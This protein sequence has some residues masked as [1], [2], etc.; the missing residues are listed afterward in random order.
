MDEQ[1][2]NPLVEA[3]VQEEIP[4]SAESPQVHADRVRQ[5][6]SDS[7]QQFETRYSNG[8]ETIVERLGEA[9]TVRPS[10][11]KTFEDP[12]AFQNAV[13]AGKAVYQLLEFAPEN[14]KKFFE[15]GLE[16]VKEGNYPKAQEVFYFLVMM[17]SDTPAFWLGL[18]FANAKLKNFEEARGAFRQV[19]DLDPKNG[20]AY[21]GCMSALLQQNAKEEALKVCEE[22]LTYADA[23]PKEPWAE[24]LHSLLE[25]A[26][27]Y[28]KNRGA[29]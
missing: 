17:A 20:D 4:S 25:E 15:V 23:H 2:L 8:Y 3:L 1:S 29:V 18:G 28:M 10:A 19:I 11:L 9:P 12:V 26:R 5:E 21:L 24:P 22:G 7:L 6:V 13:E 27:N 16:L 14:L